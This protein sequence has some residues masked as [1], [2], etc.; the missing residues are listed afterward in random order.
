MLKAKQDVPLNLLD[1]IV[2]PEKVAQEL[3]LQE[4]ATSQLIS[5]MAGSQLQADDDEDTGFVRFDGLDTENSSGLF[6][7]RDVDMD[8]NLDP[9]LS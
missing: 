4:E 8:D 7:D 1:L 3:H 9:S 2:D 6:V 5:T